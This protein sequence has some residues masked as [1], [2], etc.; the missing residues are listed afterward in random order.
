MNEHTLFSSED[1][2]SCSLRMS[3]IQLL[4]GGL[5]LLQRNDLLQLLASE[6]TQLGCNGYCQQMQSNAV[7]A[8]ADVYSTSAA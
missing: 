7:F 3:A 1:C 6:Y 2:F 8:T 4:P 5:H